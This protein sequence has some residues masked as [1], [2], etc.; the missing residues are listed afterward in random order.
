ML[1]SSC[2]SKF[3]L[4]CKYFLQLSL[5]LSFAVIVIWSCILPLHSDTGED[6]LSRWDQ[7]SVGTK[8]SISTV[9]STEVLEILRGELSAEKEKVVGFAEEQ[10]QIITEL[11]N[12]LEAFGPKLTDD[13]E[14]S[15]VTNK[16]LELENR[17]EV[18]QQKLYRVNA[19]LN[20]FSQKIKKIDRII[21]GRFSE[22]LF[23]IGPSPLALSNWQSFGSD[24]GKFVTSFSIEIKNKI[25]VMSLGTAAGISIHAL[26]W[27]S[28]IHI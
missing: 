1:V 28:L 9:K 20:E 2:N 3:A 27:L 13:E 8:N 24:L 23:S 11:L 10:E 18:E 22:K 15:S 4:L 25:S 5:K 21:R 26:F 16:R 12:Q 19:F 14:N 6:L 17:L 7:I